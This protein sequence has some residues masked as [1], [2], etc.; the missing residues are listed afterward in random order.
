MGGETMP[1]CPPASAGPTGSYTSTAGLRGGASGSG[2]YPGIRISNVS[3][4]AQPI[5]TIDGAGFTKCR[6]ID[7]TPGGQQPIFV[8]LATNEEWQAFINNVQSKVS[9]VVFQTCAIPYSTFGLAPTQSFPLPAAQQSAGCNIGTSIS[10]NTPSEFGKTGV[11]KFPA[12]IESR[13]Y[14][15][16]GGT[17]NMVSTN[18]W[19]AGNVDTSGAGTTGWIPDT[20]F[21]P[22]I[23]LR[24]ASGT[25]YQPG[26]S[27]D[28]YPA[29][30]TLYWD[31]TAS[32]SN[33]ISCYTSGW[34]GPDAS[35]NP[36]SG[37]VAVNMYGSSGFSL[38]CYENGT[39]VSTSNTYV[40]FVGAPPPPPPPPPPCCYGDGGGYYGGGG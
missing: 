2:Y 25:V 1:A 11:S 23:Y 10:Y 37:S 19:T 34:P 28:G 21:S 27:G 40:S 15:C 14:N 9:G 30:A 18:Q 31:I 4:P 7:F 17:T 5:Y 12:G 39:L 29:T 24:P 20:K 22:N 36:R 35:G 16:Y 3:S 33:P 38:T 13:A 32:N 6:W 26:Y 8:P